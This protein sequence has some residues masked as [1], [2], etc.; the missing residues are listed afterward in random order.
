MPNIPKF[1]L[2][3]ED[4]PAFAERIQSKLPLRP[5]SNLIVEEKN[6]V[7]QSLLTNLWFQKNQDSLANSLRQLN[8]R[9]MRILPAKKFL[10][11]VI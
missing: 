7:F 4:T 2:Y 10:N 6:N 3:G 1:K 8:Y 5:W 9:F 11:L